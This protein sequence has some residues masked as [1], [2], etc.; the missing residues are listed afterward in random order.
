MSFWQ[1]TPFAR[2][3]NDD[4]HDKAV[5]ATILLVTLVVPCGV[6]LLFVWLI[7]Q[8]ALV[9]SLVVGAVV[10]LSPLY[11]WGRYWWKRRR[12]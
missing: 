10:V 8:V 11:L 5:V 2:F 4:D 1:S 7:P 9:F 3:F 12:R 6:A